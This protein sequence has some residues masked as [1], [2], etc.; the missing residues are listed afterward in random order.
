MSKSL[1][2]CISKKV[3][4]NVKVSQDVTTTDL[5][6]GVGFN[7]ADKVLIQASLNA[8]K[9]ES[10]PIRPGHTTLFSTDLIWET[11]RKAIKR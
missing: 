11:D 5:F 10:A 9:L 6:P 7:S 2:C 3:K 8:N 4:T 1:S